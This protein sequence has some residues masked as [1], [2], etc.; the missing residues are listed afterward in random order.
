MERL[1]CFLGLHKMPKWSEPKKG[2]VLGESL[3]DDLTYACA[4]QERFCENCNARKLRRA[5]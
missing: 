3:D 4:M 1:L 5:S 2:D